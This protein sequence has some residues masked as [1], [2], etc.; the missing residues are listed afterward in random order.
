MPRLT[1]GRKGDEYYGGLGV[2]TDEVSDGN[3]PQLADAFSRGRGVNG[4]D[5]AEVC[6]DRQAWLLDWFGR[7]RDR[8]RV[9]RVCCGDWL[10]VCD[11]PSVTTR[12]GTTAVFLDPPYPT[13]AK[14]RNDKLYATDFNG[15][16]LSQLRDEVL[17]YCTE[18]GGDP[19]MKIC[20]AG[21]DTDGYAALEAE[22]WDCVEWNA[23]GGYGNRSEK[24]KANAGRERLW[25]S[26][27]CKREKMLFDAIPEHQAG[28]FAEPAP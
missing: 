19:L 21:Y 23:A 27:H 24:G 18:R 9:V 12:L 22:G 15:K 5:T 28:L 4:N 11:S 20:V 10:R 13:E 25:F 2:H 3:R 26:P 8:L 6:A 14:S 1:E 16:C 17:A 7:L